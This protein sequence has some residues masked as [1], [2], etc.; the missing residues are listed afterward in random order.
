MKKL[1][2]LFTLALLVCCGNVSAQTEVS[3][4]AELKAAGNPEALATT[5][6]IIYN[7][8]GTTVA[9]SANA[10]DYYI[11]DE[12]GAICVTNVSGDCAAFKLA[13]GTKITSGKMKV[14]Y[15]PDKNLFPKIIKAEIVEDLVTESGEPVAHDMLTDQIFA[16]LVGNNQVAD[17]A[18]NGK[19]FWGYSVKATGYIKD[20][21]GK[22]NFFLD[23]ER[24]GSSIRTYYSYMTAVNKT[25]AATWGG[26]T[27]TKVVVEGAF[28]NDGFHA[29]KIYEAVETGIGSIT[30]KSEAKDNAVYSLNGTLVSKNGSTEGLNKGIYI[31]NGKK[32]VIR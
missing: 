27:A 3:S 21:S 8:A 12:T 19:E 14:S 31:V 6:G 18:K 13:A 32:V 24:T 1:N 28:W 30:V 5:E 16:E 7:L 4:I 2:F 23:E 17:W 11:E 10:K 25:E 9:L 29:T 20:I 15:Q 26:E 22:A